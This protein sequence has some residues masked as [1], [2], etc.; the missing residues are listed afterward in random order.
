MTSNPDYVAVK[1][2]V[3]DNNVG[4]RLSMKLRKLGN[5]FDPE[6]VILGY[7]AAQLNNL[8]RKRLLEALEVDALATAHITVSDSY[9][10]QIDFSL[11]GPE[12][13]TPIWLDRVARGP[14]AGSAS[15]WRFG[16]VLVREN[17]NHEKVL[18]GLD[19]GYTELIERRE[20]AERALC[21]GAPCPD[22]AQLSASSTTAA[23][24]DRGT[25]AKLWGYVGTGANVP[26]QS[27]RSELRG[28]AEFDPAW[29]TTL[30]MGYRV[31][32][33]LSL[34]GRLDFGLGPLNRAGWEEQL[35]HELNMSYLIAI[36]PSIAV[37]PWYD[38]EL[39]PYLVVDG[40]LTRIG[41][42]SG[43][44]T[45]DGNFSLSPS[46]PR[47]DPGLPQIGYNGLSLGTALGLRYGT[48]ALETR[49]QHTAWLGFSEGGVGA[50]SE[51]VDQPLNQLIITLGFTS[52]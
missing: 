34:G 51:L 29:L 28:G 16:N 15:G 10:A 43:G 6:G 18:T 23:A 35:R 20:V 21:G 40:M 17:I 8:Q 24:M 31:K 26:I 9:R 4:A 52:P 22:R 47:Y 32:P 5:F 13:Q 39:E 49:Y 46:D 50:E 3:F 27:P 45:T 7:Y 2:E 42:A 12:E 33:W 11:L 19:L 30:A 36:G 25:P 37:R 1:K 14:S 48:W 44:N 41:T 38:L